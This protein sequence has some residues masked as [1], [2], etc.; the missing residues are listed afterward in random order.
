MVLEIKLSLHTILALLKSIWNIIPSLL[1]IIVRPK[2]TI[3]IRNQIIETEDINGNIHHYNY[4]S[5]LISFNRGVK[6]DI[7]SIRLNNE[8]YMCLLSRDDNF[9]KQDKN[10]KHPITVKNNKLMPFVKEN[11]L[12]LTGRSLYL[13][14]DRLEVIVLPLCVKKQGVNFLFLPLKTTKTFLP[15]NKL[16]LSLNIDGKDFEYSL[17]LLSVCKVVIN[18]LAFAE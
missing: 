16:I 8:T 17:P 7:G 3:Q 18:H 13:S 12:A 9:L 4:P 5:V 1:N 11:W 2:A 15:A 10:S 14:F 6:I